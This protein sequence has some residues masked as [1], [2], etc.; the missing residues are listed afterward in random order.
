MVKADGTYKWNRKIR[1]NRGVTACVR[2]TDVRS[3]TVF[4]ARI[5]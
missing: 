4:W 5:T 3:N 1:K 2:W